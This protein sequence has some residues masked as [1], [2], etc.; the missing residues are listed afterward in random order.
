[1]KK[2]ILYVALSLTA[3][4]GLVNCAK[5]GGSSSKTATT[6]VNNC[7]VGQVWHSSYGCLATAQCQSMGPNYGYYQGQ[8]YP[9][10]VG[11]AANCRGSCQAGYVQTYNGCM[12]AATTAQCGS[13]YTCAGYGPVNG[14]PSQCVPGIDNSMYYGN[15]YG[16]QYPQQ[17]YYGTG[18]YPY[19]YQQYPYYN[20]YNYYPYYGNGGLYFYMGF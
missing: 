9:G 20:Q 6:G 8:C 19:Y 14:G 5:D 16:N 4:F 11:G 2:T 3:V 13:Q 17:Q 1:M 10:Q 7:G 18:Y 15:G 12:K